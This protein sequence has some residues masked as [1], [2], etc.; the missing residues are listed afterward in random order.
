MKHVARTD[1]MGISRNIGS[2]SKDLKTRAHCRED[3]VR[4][5][6]RETLCEVVDWIQVAQNIVK[7]ETCECFWCHKSR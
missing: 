6:V 3:K 1:E 2:C 4:T 7:W 5:D